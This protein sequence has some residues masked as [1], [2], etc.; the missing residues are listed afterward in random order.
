M[1]TPIRYSPISDLKKIDSDS[2]VP[3]DNRNS[4]YHKD[5]LQNLVHST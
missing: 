3:N 2:V 4:T 1:I 5:S